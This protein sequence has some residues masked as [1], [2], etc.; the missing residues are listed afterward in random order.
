LSAEGVAKSVPVHPGE[1][2]LSIAATIGRPAIIDMEAC[3]HDGFVVF[4]ELSE[5]VNPDYLYHFLR[6]M[7][8]VMEAKGLV[9]TQKNINTNIVNNMCLP[10][11]ELSVQDQLSS[12]MNELLDSNEQYES[13]AKLI[14]G[15]GAQCLS[16]AGTDV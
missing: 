2:I 4:K 9:G 5:R 10:L 16:S 12:L 3:I 6:W 7:K 13:R 11:P 8:P 15:I 14:A 1:V